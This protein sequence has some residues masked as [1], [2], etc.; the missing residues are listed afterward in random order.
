VNAN[1]AARPD[2]TTT[3]AKASDMHHLFDGAY[4]DLSIVQFESEPAD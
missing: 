2:Q 4:C 3:T 1:Y